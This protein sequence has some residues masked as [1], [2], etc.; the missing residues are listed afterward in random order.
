LEKHR[1]LRSTLT[2]KIK[3]SLFFIFG[4]Q[5]ESIN[6]KAALEKVLDWKRSDKTKLCYKR[7]FEKIADNSEDTYMSRILSKIWPSGNATHEQVAYAI[8][9]CQTVLDPICEKITISED[10]VKSKIA[11]NLVNILLLFIF[12]KKLY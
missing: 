11:R 1:L 10:L 8:A 3:D 5:L 7:L 12:I 4:D 2:T 6:N 9:I